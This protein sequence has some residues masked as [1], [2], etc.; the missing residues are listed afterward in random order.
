MRLDL[1]GHFVL[2]FHGTRRF[3]VVAQQL[4][5]TCAVIHRQKAIDMP[6]VSRKVVTFAALDAH[7][8]SGSLLIGKFLTCGLREFS[9][10]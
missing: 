10:N 6:G 7:L 8:N 3:N 1:P 2:W 4:H 5:W 9:W